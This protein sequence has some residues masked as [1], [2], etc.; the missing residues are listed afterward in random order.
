M[1]AHRFEGKVALVTGA[2]SGVGRATAVRLAREGAAVALLA[3]G[4]EGL[5]GARREVEAAGGRALV[6]Q[7]DVA[8]PQAVED[9]AER[10]EA[11][12]GPLDVWVNNAMIAVLAPFIEHDLADFKRVTDV[13]YLGVV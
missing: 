7:A 13:T 5:E 10:A 8:D 6:L 9:A 3:R 12:L 11:E 1:A 4:R 2:S